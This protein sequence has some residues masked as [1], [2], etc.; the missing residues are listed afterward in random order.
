MLSTIKTDK[1]Y[2]D[3]TSKAQQTAAY[4]DVNKQ[5]KQVQNQIHDNE[6]IAGKRYSNAIRRSFYALS[7]AA[8]L[9]AAAAADY[10]F[11]EGK[12]MGAAS[13]YMPDRNTFSNYA[14]D[15]NTFSKYT[16]DRDTFGKYAPD[17]NTFSKYTPDRNT[18]SNYTPDV[19]G[20]LSSAYQNAPDVRGRL[21]RMYYGTPSTTPQ[22]APTSTG[23]TF[24]QMATRKSQEAAVGLAATEALRRGANRGQR[25][26]NP[27]E[28][29]F[30]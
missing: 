20:R 11:N 21:S 19:R 27:E 17:R 23:E 26:L 13:N 25:Y 7:T 9:G 18:L 30:E 29:M 14:P 10:Y 12:V 24:S 22:V 4:N 8:A 6:V 1:Q 28:T 16:P 5:L 2:I 3:N 15:R